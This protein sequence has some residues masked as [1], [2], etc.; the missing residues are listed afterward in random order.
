MTVKFLCPHCKNKEATAERI[1]S[2]DD[3]NW[4]RNGLDSELELWQCENCGSV[5]VV[6]I[7]D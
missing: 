6:N 4:L 1:Q 2:S 3:L 5:T 7:L